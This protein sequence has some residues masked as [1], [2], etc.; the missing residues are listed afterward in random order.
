MSVVVPVHGVERY[1][2]D[3][4][5]SLLAQT[6]PGIEVVAV[7]DA[8]PDGSLDIL[9]AYE[10]EHPGR[11]VVVDSPTNRRQGGAR[12]LG[13]A[14]ASGEFLG[15]VDADDWVDPTMYEKL[16]A[17]ARDTGADVVDCDLLQARGEPHRLTREVSCSPEQTGPRS[18]ER[19]RALIRR[20]S[21][22]VTKIVRRSLFTEHD[23]RFPEQVAYEDNAL[24]T[25]WCLADRV[26][27]VDDALYYYRINA[28]STVRSRDSAIVADRLETAEQMVR[29]AQAWGVYDDYPDEVEGRFVE[30]YYL[31]TIGP[32]LFRFD[33]P[34]RSRLIQLRAT[35]RTRFP[36][37][38][39]RPAFRHVARAPR[40][41]SGLNDLSP[42]LLCAIA[43]AVRAVARVTP[44][45]LRP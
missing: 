22:I 34:Q 40:V 8:S 32:C 30:L 14:A 3:C 28:G 4:L 36:D 29:N 45:A 9:R 41:V 25:V 20:G 27:K 44:R 7:N 2:R 18:A 10:R 1:L 19:D 21:R 35:A 6:L 26:E 16:V 31:N 5:D 24:A 15:F 13:I 11:V 39:R 12:N 17:R 42:T 38:R 37:Y 43:W 33:R 23:V